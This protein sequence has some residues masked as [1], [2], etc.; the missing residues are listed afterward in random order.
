MFRVIPH[1]NRR[2]EYRWEISCSL[3]AAL[4]YCHQACVFYTYMQRQHV[5]TLKTAEASDKE[6]LFRSAWQWLF[7]DCRR[8]SAFGEARVR[9][10]NSER[11]LPFID[12]HRFAFI[13]DLVMSTRHLWSHFSSVML[14]L[15][16]ITHSSEF[17]KTTFYSFLFIN[18]SDFHE[19]KTSEP[20]DPGAKGRIFF[21]LYLGD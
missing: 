10:E 18:Y 17:I 2:Y 11:E 9:E 6:T 16:F 8:I 21:M 12:L 5:L 20:S 4:T 13:K 7:S 1:L 3:T 19:H 14:S 15:V